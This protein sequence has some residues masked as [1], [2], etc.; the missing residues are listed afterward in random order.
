M[1]PHC[2]LFIN[3]TENPTMHSP[4]FESIHTLCSIH[5]IRNGVFLR[6]YAGFIFTFPLMCPIVQDAGNLRFVPRFRR[7]SNVQKAG[8]P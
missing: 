8:H 5:F 6:L 4:H 7:L 1:Q 2:F 3:Q